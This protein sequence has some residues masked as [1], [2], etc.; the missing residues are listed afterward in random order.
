MIPIRH[1]HQAT[2]SPNIACPSGSSEADCVLLAHGEGGRLMRKLL[3]DRIL[4]ILGAPAVEDAASFLG[5]PGK[6][7]IT[8]DSYVVSPL[9]FPGGDIGSMAVYGTVNDLAVSGA[10]TICL[11]LSLILEEG[12]SLNILDR[13]LHS[14]AL[15]A[16][17]C[18]VPIVAGDTKV[19]PRGAADKLFINT[20]G[21]GRYRSKSRLSCTSIQEGDVLIVSGPIGQHGIA[22]LASRENLGLN[23]EPRSDSATLQL[24]CSALQDALG[25]DLRT[26]RDA[27][28]GG[29][30]AVLHEWAE[31]SNKTMKL[32]ECKI[33]VASDVQAVC[34]LLGLDPLYVANEGTFVAAVAPTAVDQAMKTL[35]SQP[36]S[37]AAQV[38]GHVLQKQF[39]PVVVERM[40]GVLQPIDEPSG[41]PLPRIC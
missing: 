22:V 41:A 20:T 27:T 2:A 5:A 19:V 10:E 30:S 32:D 4:P 33:P 31:A 16:K 40:L 15:A 1:I 24:S 17:E 26:M 14:I 7:A 34:E 38:I 8:T 28:R 11:T 25:C 18:G 39:S 3:R 36:V 13:V 23:P 35:R 9:F 6:L 37:A 21:V 29:V 12:L